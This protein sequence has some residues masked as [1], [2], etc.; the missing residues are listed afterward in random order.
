MPVISSFPPSALSLPQ[1]PQT[2]LTSFLFLNWVSFEAAAG[3]DPDLRH[4]IAR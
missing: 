4:L 1:T 2:S 3:K